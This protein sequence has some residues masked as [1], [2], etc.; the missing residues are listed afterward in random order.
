MSLNCE[1]NRFWCRREGK[2]SWDDLGFLENPEVGYNPD[3]VPFS[4]ISDVPCLVLL[5]EP[6]IGKST[7]LEKEYERVQ[8][9]LSQSPDICLWR[10]LGEYGS[11]EELCKDVFEYCQVQDWQQGNHKLHLFLDSLDEGRLSVPILV[12]ILKRKLKVLPSD[13]LYFRITCRTADWPDSLE[14]ELKQKWGEDNVQIYEL[15]PLRQVDFEEAAQANNIKDRSA[16]LQEILEKEAV[17]LAIKPITL[18]FILSTYSENGKLPDSQRELYEQGCLELC[19]E[20]NPDRRESGFVGKLN[21][22]QRLMV[23]GR[24]AALLLF[25]NRAAISLQPE[26]GETP[27]SLLSIPDLCFGEESVKNQEIKINEK[28]IRDVLDTGLFSSRGA[29]RM[30]FA[31]QTYAEFLAAW[32]LDRRNLPL[33]QIMSLIVLPSDSERKLVPQLRETAAWL[34]SMRKDVLEEIIKTDPDVLLRSDIPKDE[35]LK[36]AIVEN[37]LKHYDE[38]KLFSRGD[39]YNYRAYYKKLS[40]PGLAEQLRP[41]V[42]DPSKNR[43]VRYEAISIAEVCEI[44]EL[45]EDM[46]NVVLA[47]SQDILLRI[48][49]ARAV[50]LL[51]D[52]ETKS[53]LK[54]LILEKLP[55]DKNDE[56]KGYCLAALWPENL[57]VEELFSALT[58]PKNTTPFG[59]YKQFIDRQVITELSSKELS[60]TD[61]ELALNWV[62]KQ[63]VRSYGDPFESLADAILLKAWE[64]FDLPGV[65]ERF[66]EIALIQWRLH[67]GII[68]GRFYSG[69]LLASDSDREQFDLQ[70][71]R[72]DR[73]RRKLLEHIVPIAATEEDP[74]FLWTETRKYQLSQDI[75][76]TIERLE[77]ASD[78]KEQTIWANLIKYNFDR[79]NVEH[80]SL[81]ASKT[82]EFLL[83]EQINLVLLKELEF[84][85]DPVKLDSDRAEK[86]EADY[87]WF[88][89]RDKKLK[90]D[91]KKQKPSLLDPPPKERI[92]LLLDL[93]ESGNLSAWCQIN[94]EMTLKPDSKYYGN[95]WQSDLTK[96]PGW[97]DASAETRSRIIAGAKKYIEEQDEVSYDWR[98]TNKYYFQELTGYNAFQLLLQESPE[99]VDSISKTIWQKW[100]PIII[101]FAKMVNEKHLELIERAYQNSPFESLNTLTLLIDRENKQD[102]YLL[103]FQKFPN[104]WDDRLH[105][106]LLE[107]AKDKALKPEC[108]GQLLSYLLKHQSNEARKFAISLI[109]SQL[110]SQKEEY[111]KAITAAK[112]LIGYVESYEWPVIWQVIE[113]DNNFGREV[114]EAAAYRSYNRSDT[115]LKLNE[116]QLADLYIWIEEEYARDVVP[117]PDPDSPSSWEITGRNRIPNFK[118]SILGQLRDCGSSEACQEIERI[119]REFP[120]LTWMKQIAFDAHNIRRRKSWQAPTP[121]DIINLIEDKSKRLVQ[122]GVQLLEVLI[123]VL[124][125]LELELQGESAAR[126]LWD[127]HFEKNIYRPISENSFS[128]YVKRYLDS[129]LKDRA[130]VLNREVQVIPNPGGSLGQ[131]IDIKADRIDPEKG[132]DDI[133]VMIEVKGCWNKKEL[134]TGIHQQLVD[135]Y[136]KETRIQYGLYLIG[137]FYC[138]RWD[139]SHRQKKDTPKESIKDIRKRFNN[140][141]VKLSSSPGVEVRAF[142]I[143]AALR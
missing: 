72:S 130:I 38:D 33:K 98:D 1:L 103:T 91:N 43:E 55:E 64:H 84:Y 108:M 10:S 32:Y 11:E 132:D 12:R 135:R 77:N 63:G 86:M 34:A 124:E 51:G 48:K 53:R 125:D 97:Q 62:K 52:S 138:E 141:A 114:I 92:L 142:V 80:I 67:Q 54:P 4:K 68:T 73:K 129:R 23:A 107:K 36:A 82:N 74:Y 18:K 30:G 22:D 45:Q 140:K 8:Q 7:E 27:N 90:D 81:I 57:T 49:A 111:Q 19:K 6:G 104:F 139:N 110:P 99:S 40:H 47:S 112:V 89:E 28:D 37:L 128:D 76:W 134:N 106:V 14:Q 3:L 133:T 42:Q 117:E 115:S 120:N 69:G 15:A 17:P 100:A 116:K 2:L 16:F 24:I 123:E 50:C 96:L 56:L 119:A 121:T 59:V 13:R 35:G 83:G 31:H 21:E 26:I 65:A 87:I 9:E 136:L 75:A 58:A 60:S 143:N 113:Q 105:S 88:Q 20:V 71:A 95:L 70:V 101:G 85:F 137:W 44:R 131:R 78:P 109:P 102:G 127:K 118:D 46:I 122:D 79:Q 25:A 29:N 66:A 126:D 39:G 94:M 5:G 41:Y 61:L 93:L